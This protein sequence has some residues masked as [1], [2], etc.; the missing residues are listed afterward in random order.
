MIKDRILRTGDGSHSL[1][2][3]RNS[4]NDLDSNNNERDIEHFWGFGDKTM[5][6]DDLKNVKILKKSS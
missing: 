4:K 1:S 2:K 5:T 3:E 6:K